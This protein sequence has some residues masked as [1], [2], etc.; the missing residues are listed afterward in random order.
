MFTQTE[1]KLCNKHISTKK[2]VKIFNNFFINSVD[3][4]I[5]Q[6]PKTESALFSLRE[7][8]P[9]ELLQIISIPITE[10]EVICIKK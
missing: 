9:H 3:E 1:F 8:F 7:S 4:L 2:S 6:Q 5:T 10:T